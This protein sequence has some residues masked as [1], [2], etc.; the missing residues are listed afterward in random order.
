MKLLTSFVDRLAALLALPIS[1]VA[2]ASAAYIFSE[3]VNPCVIW[4]ASDSGSLYS[5]AHAPCKEVKGEGETRIR[6][7]IMLVVVQGV[8]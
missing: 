4:R 6:A 1:I 5:S 2:I 7:C 3:L 8:R